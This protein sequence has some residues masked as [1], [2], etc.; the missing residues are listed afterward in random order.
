MHIRVGKDNL[1][2]HL[3]MPFP[4]IGKYNRLLQTVLQIVFLDNSLLLEYLLVGHVT[5]DV[6]VI[7][8]QDIGRDLLNIGRLF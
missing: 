5:D 6:Y 4:F 2:R 7:C 3:S 1:P 8:T